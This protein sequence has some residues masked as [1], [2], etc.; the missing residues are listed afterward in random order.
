MPLILWRGPTNALVLQPNS[1][2]LTY[3][4]RVKAVDVYKGPQSLCVTSMIPRGTF[5]TGYRTGWVCTQSEVLT[6]RGTIG[7]L[8]L[9]WE[10]G[11][12]NAT[13]PLPVGSFSMD[14][15]ELY[16][17]V[18]RAGVF[19]PLTFDTINIVYNCLYSANSSGNPALTPATLPNQTP[20]KNSLTDPAQAQQLALAKKLLDKLQKGE[21]TF[22]IAGWR[23]SYEVYSYTQPTL[24][25]G[26][27]VVSGTP[28]GPISNFPAGVSWL[29]LA[30]KVDPAGVA[31][32]MYKTTFNFIGGPILNG[33]GYWD[34]DVYS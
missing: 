28:G 9:E 16:P 15:Q 25:N 13:Q 2:R 22:Y 24:N 26:G 27:F 29:R 8:T 34:P 11:G 14:P 17:K 21:E 18:E 20:F 33:V 31:G 12:Y 3:G 32:S 23:Y 5:G 4:D 7:T 19:Q 6:E 1:P 10:A 30:D